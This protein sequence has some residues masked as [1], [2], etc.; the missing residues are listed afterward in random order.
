MLGNRVLTG[1]F[2]V[3]IDRLRS[4]AKEHGKGQ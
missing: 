1:R 4:S 2:D 3:G